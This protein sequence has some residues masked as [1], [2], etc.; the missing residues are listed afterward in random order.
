MTSAMITILMTMI[1]RMIIM[2]IMPSL[3]M[4]ITRKNYQT[5]TTLTIV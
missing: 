4:A 5:N 1:V 3:L 2:K